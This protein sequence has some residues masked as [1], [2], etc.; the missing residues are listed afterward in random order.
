M[1]TLETTLQIPADV[2]FHELAGEAVLL[3]LESGK[4]FGLDET[5]TRMWMLIAEHGRLEPVV[6]ALLEEYDV[7][8]EQ[9]RKDLFE[10]VE[11]LVASG[12][13]TIA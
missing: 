3:H 8:E 1:L 6:Q 13:V 10:L 9:L 4:Y 7:S 11:R 2:L 5:G 12:L